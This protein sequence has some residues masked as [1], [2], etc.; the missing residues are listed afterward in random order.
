V[1]AVQGG[2]PPKTQ[3]EILRAL[4]PQGPY[5]QQAVPWII[6]GV[7]TALWA[8]LFLATPASAL[9]GKVAVLRTWRL[10]RGSFLNILV[11]YFIVRLPIILTSI[12]VGAA[13]NGQIVNLTAAQI[14]G[15]SVLS[16]IM[17]GAASAPLTAGLQ[18]YFYKVL[19]PLA[20]PEQ[21]AVTGRS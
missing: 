11:S 9:S 18:A 1:L 5:I 13:M 19:G 6:L 3:E 21:K 14:L 10:T 7:S 2:P 20:P 17:A 4:G 16:G 15:Y 8:R 12:V